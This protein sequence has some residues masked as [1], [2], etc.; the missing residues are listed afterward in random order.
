MTGAT[1]LKVRLVPCL[2]VRDG[3]AFLKLCQIV[4]AQGGDPD[5]L[6]DDALLPSARGSLDVPAPASGNV[7]ATDAGATGLAAGALGA[8]RARLE[9]PVDHGVGLV[10][11]KKVGEA[12]RAG[13]PLCTIH[14]G[15]GGREAPE[16]V[17]D[18]VVRAYQIGDHPLSPE[19]LILGRIEG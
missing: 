8:G 17:A 11:H 4:E 5:A 6:A 3:R 7:Q 12:V 16:A 13:E 15:A 1:D 2:D 9:D 19:P 10:V 18:R 14:H